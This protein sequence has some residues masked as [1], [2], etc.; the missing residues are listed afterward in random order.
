MAKGP[1]FFLTLTILISVSPTPSDPTHD[2][3]ILVC[4]L[5]CALRIFPFLSTSEDFSSSTSALPSLAPSVSASVLFIAHTLGHLT[6][7]HSLH[8]IH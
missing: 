2:A 8:P 7:P 4:S 1:V 6:P 5:F 3:Q